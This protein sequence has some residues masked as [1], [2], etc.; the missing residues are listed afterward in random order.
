MNCVADIYT[1]CGKLLH[2]F[3]GWL[4]GRGSGVGVV[5]GQILEEVVVE[6]EGDAAQQVGVDGLSLEDVVDV[7]AVAVELPGKPSHGVRLGPGV[8]DLF[9]S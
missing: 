7:A 4:R 8:E 1:G 3:S 5:V 9:Y 2:T 6:D